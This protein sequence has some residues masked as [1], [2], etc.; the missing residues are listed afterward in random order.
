MPYYDN[1]DAEELWHVINTYADGVYL[2]EVRNYLL[3]SVDDSKIPD[4]RFW[5][6][7]NE[8]KPIDAWWP[9]RHEID[10]LVQEGIFEPEQW[11]ETTDP[12]GAVRRYKLTSESERVVSLQE[13][14]VLDYLAERGIHEHHHGDIT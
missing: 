3:S 11:R 5:P 2:L 4:D 8:G 13:D 7:D 10:A 12:E 1:V 14:E 6:M 9:E